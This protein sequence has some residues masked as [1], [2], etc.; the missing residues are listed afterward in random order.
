MTKWLV[1][2][3]ALLFAIGGLFALLV[4]SFA[5]IL[6][7]R[8]RPGIDLTE[9]MLRIRS[10]WIMVILFS[11]ALVSGSVVSIILFALVSFFALKEY[12]SLIQVRQADR[13][14]LF[15]QAAL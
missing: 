5:A 11:V 7:R 1:T 2:D 3:P 13:R 6:F 10:W 9:V 12:L 4:G 14:V 8:L 15:W